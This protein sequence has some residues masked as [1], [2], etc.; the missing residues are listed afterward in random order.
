MHRKIAISINLFIVIFAFAIMPA[1]AQKA[2]EQQA[3]QLAAAPQTVTVP[4]KTYHIGIFAPL[5]LDSVFTQAGNFRFKQGIPK[6]IIPGLEFVQ[7]AELALDSMNLPNANIVAA[8]YDS[9]SYDQPIPEL[10]TEKKL[11]SLDIIIGNVKDIEYKQL[12]DFALQK[13]IPFISATYPN[14][15]GVS[16]NPYLVIVNP[17]LKSHC[18]AIYSYLLENHG[19]DKIYL[20]RK[21][22]T[23]EDKIADYFKAINIQDGKPLLNIQTL[24][25]DADQQNSDFLKKKLDSTKQ[26]IIIGG[27]LDE[28]F[29]T[30]LTLACHDLYPSYPITLIGM[31]N[32]EGFKQ[33]TKSDVFGDF[34]IYFTSPYFNDKLDSNSRALMNGY[35]INYKGKP[36]DM[37]FK[38]YEC[39]SL[40]TNLLIKYSTAVM[41]NLN[42]KTFKVFSDYNFRPVMLTKYEFPDYFEN[43]H[44]YF[45]KITNGN[46]S[47]A[48]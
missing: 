21:K 47:R 2:L 48:W 40:F 28:A 31:P 6:L 27:S 34:P 22:G 20:V 11:D 10:I 19:T 15:G 18:E 12:A 1:T 37:A 33:L 3:A 32:W 39:A 9:K 7:G 26:T 30:N 4:M 23:Q 14:D 24:S 35:M 42:D 46:L 38:G 45:I 41:N 29:A 25:F 8:I 13:K 5:Y 36:T 17:T 43:K 16:G 44:L